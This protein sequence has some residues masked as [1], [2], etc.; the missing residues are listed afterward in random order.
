MSSP[1]LQPIVGL[2]PYDDPAIDAQYI[3]FLLLHAIRS[4]DWVARL[5][6][7]LVSAQV[8]AQAVA[9]SSALAPPG[10]VRQPAR[11]LI[12]AA[13]GVV[14]GFAHPIPLGFRCAR[15]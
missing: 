15:V 10:S 4:A 2:D 11:A 8:H 6:L 5:G 9:T 13:D 7:C 3:L 1:Q 12:P 14:R